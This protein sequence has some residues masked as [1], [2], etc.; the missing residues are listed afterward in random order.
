MP[1][2]AHQKSYKKTL[3]SPRSFPSSLLTTSDLADE[4]RV[5]EVTIKVSRKTGMLLGARAP[6]YVKVGRLVRYRRVDIDT[7]IKRLPLKKKGVEPIK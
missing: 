1:I 5:S 6:P 4:L 2:D 7:W 3:E